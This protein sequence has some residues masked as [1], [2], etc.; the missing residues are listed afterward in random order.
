[1]NNKLQEIWNYC[2]DTQKTIIEWGLQNETYHQAQIIEL[3][4]IQYRINK[5]CTNSQKF[6]EIKWIYLKEILI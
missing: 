3:R 2:H 5:K 6:K 1:M 4:K